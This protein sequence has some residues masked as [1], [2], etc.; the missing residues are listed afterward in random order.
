MKKRLK[1]YIQS[2]RFK[3]HLFLFLCLFGCQLAAKDQSIDSLKRALQYTNN[4]SNKCA[5][6]SKLA[7]MEPDDNLWPIYN[8]QVY[9]ISKNKVISGKDKSYYYHKLLIASSNNKGYLFNL[10]GQIDSSIIYF[11]ECLILSEKINDKENF[12]ESLYNIGKA[13]NLKGNIPKALELQA[14]SLA[15]AEK[16]NFAEL[17]AR[18]LIS[19]GLTH[20]KQKDL[21]KALEYYKKAYNIQLKIKD[22]RGSGYSLTN[23]AGI[24]LDK[25]DYP[26]ALK[27]F[28]ESK[29][30]LQQINDYSGYLM[31]L[32][33]IAKIYLVNKDFDNAIENCNKII[34]DDQSAI[35]KPILASTHDMLGAIYLDMNEIDRALTNNLLAMKIAKEIQNPE[36]IRNSA[37]ALTK[38]YKKLKKH[39]LAL[40]NYEL[41]ILMRDSIYSQET[42]KAS[43]KSQ[44]KYEYEKKA[45][46][47]SVKVAEEKKLTQIQLKQDETQRYF[48]YGGLALTIVFGII[49][50]NRFKVAQKQK[51]IIAEQKNIVEKQKHIVDEKQKEIMDSIHYAKRI[52]QSL[53]PTEKYISK[54][55]NIKF[56]EPGP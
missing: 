55:L 21:A 28:N 14:R 5:I 23:I 39:Q 49:M 20:H 35:Y 17:T 22:K 30:L 11:N 44:L 46:A 13:Y 40:D 51:N 9:K 1:G 7:E 8:D 47:D 32:R 6:L 48:L 25:K 38:N 41:Y 45:T 2:I 19:I 24:Y 12:A 31:A 18:V 33:N 37:F 10:I 27:Y 15:I 3:S 42:R 34:N 56:N 36:L 50:F 16:E 52:Q 54:N 43:I 53:L 26:N 29:Q 4:D